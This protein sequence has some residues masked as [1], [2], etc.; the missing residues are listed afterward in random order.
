M[1]CYEAM[2]ENHFFPLKS[3]GIY[4]MALG[5]ASLTAILFMAHHPKT[6]RFLNVDEKYEYFVSEATSPAKIPA[7]VEMTTR[8]AALSQQ[9]GNVAVTLPPDKPY[10]WEAKHRSEMARRA[11]RKVVTE[12]FLMNHP[13]KLKDADKLLKTFEVRSC[14]GKSLRA[15]NKSMMHMIL[16][17]TRRFYAHRSCSLRTGKA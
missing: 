6:A 1:E 7:E 12:F 5:V 14:E 3:L 17:L 2:S 15:G 13:R 11:A 16:N 10:N 8:F 4:V 9:I